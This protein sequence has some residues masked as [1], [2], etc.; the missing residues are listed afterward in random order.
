MSETP[1]ARRVVAPK[2]KTREYV[3]D[4][5][6]SRSSQKKIKEFSVPEQQTRCASD[7]A[8]II[9]SPSE[10]DLFGLNGELDVFDLIKNIGVHAIS[11]AGVGLILFT[12]GFIAY[13]KLKIFYSLTC[14]LGA[15]EIFTFFII[16][17][18]SEEYLDLL[19]GSAQDP[20]FSLLVAVSLI[21][22]NFAFR[23]LAKIIKTYAAKYV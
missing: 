7:G 10:E 2:I 21:S 6:L 5:Q 22:I 17:D 20:K 4:E 12:L 8:G 18:K 11:C 15:A 3:S 16:S 13:N 19:K 14:V 23:V 9:P 1:K